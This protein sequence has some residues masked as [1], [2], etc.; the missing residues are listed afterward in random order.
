M[1]ADDALG[2][3]HDQMPAPVAAESVG[4]NPEELVA[5]AEPRSP[6]ARPR[7]QC[8]LMTE[9]EILGDERLAVAHGRTE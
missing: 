1:P 7:Q 2:S 8:E 9:Q 4:H 6:P 3:E 5:G